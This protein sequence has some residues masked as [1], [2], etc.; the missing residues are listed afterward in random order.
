LGSSYFGPTRLHRFSV[1]R[2]MVD[3]L[4]SSQHLGSSRM[5]YLHQRSAELFAMFCILS[6]NSSQKLSCLFTD[7]S[8]FT[9]IPIVA[10]VSH[11][12]LYAFNVVCWTPKILGDKRVLGQRRTPSYKR[13]YKACLGAA[14]GYITPSAQ[15]L[16]IKD[17]VTF[18]RDSFSAFQICSSWIKCCDDVGQV[19]HYAS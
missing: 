14:L 19:Y 18:F 4:S 10:Y 13:K 5:R 17:R 16:V 1:P 15:V 8:S 9:L 2:C 7:T 12:L 6:V 3:G 11:T